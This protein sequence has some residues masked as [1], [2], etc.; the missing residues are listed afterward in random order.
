M[1]SE[2]EAEF[3]FMIFFAA[4]GLSGFWLGGIAGL[5]VGAFFTG[6]IALPLIARITDGD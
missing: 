6:A 4:G 1:L 5:I 2:R 3:A